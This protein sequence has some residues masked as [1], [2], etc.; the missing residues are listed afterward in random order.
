[1]KV[2]GVTACPTGIAHTYM[3][4][5][6]IEQAAKRLGFDVKVE[7]RGSVG[8]ENELTSEDI[9]NADVIVL[10]CDTTVPTDRFIGKKVICVGVS[11]AIKRATE[12]IEIGLSKEPFNGTLVNEKTVKK[13]KEGEEGAGGFFANLFKKK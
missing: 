5:E 10:A 8:V 1:M 4:A 11:D 3:A 12:I 13:V 2:L 7:T 6:A 9:A